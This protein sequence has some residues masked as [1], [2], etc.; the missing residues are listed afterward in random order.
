M[1]DLD[2]GVC[3]QH[4]PRR[5]SWLEEIRIPDPAGP[6]SLVIRHAAVVLPAG[7]GAMRGEPGG[8]PVVIISLFWGVDLG[9]FKL[10]KLM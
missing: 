7:R 4:G 3:G 10:K 2:P 9:D 6:G 8:Y 5:G 1:D